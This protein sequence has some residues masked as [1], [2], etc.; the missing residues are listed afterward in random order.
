MR[1]FIGLYLLFFFLFSLLQA[2]NP[3]QAVKPLGAASQGTL[4]SAEWEPADSWNCDVQLPPSPSSPFHRLVCSQGRVFGGSSSGGAGPT[5]AFC[6]SFFVQV[7]LLFKETFSSPVVKWDFFEPQ[8][9]LPKATL[10]GACLV[11][12]VCISSWENN[13][14]SLFKVRFVSFCLILFLRQ[15]RERAPIGQNLWRTCG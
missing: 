12:T 4:G 10:C 15:V 11:F 1:V 5:I 7:L 6:L 2:V 14:L 9:P 8:F 3:G 13:C